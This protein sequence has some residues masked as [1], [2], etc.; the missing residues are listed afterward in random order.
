MH[1]MR[2]INKT[3]S[4]LPLVSGVHLTGWMDERRQTMKRSTLR[5]MFRTVAASAI[6][7]VPVGTIL[8][9]DAPLAAPAEQQAAPRSA[10]TPQQ[11]DNLVAP[12]AL[13]PDPWLSQV[14]VAAT[15][16]LEVVQANQWLQQNRS[17]TGTGLMDA[18]KQQNWDPSVQALVA[19]PDVLTRLNQDV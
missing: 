12:L 1:R 5:S 3:Q 2:L 9:Q 15:Y 8:A 17:L 7:F 19:F 6:L 4:S 13:Y 14:L 18:A 10:L 16:P 11:L